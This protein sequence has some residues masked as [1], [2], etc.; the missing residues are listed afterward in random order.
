MIYQTVKSKYIYIYIYYVF[1]GLIIT[2][3]FS[4]MTCE[5]VRPCKLPTAIIPIALVRLLA[6]VR[7]KMLLQVRA[8]QIGLVAIGEIA[9]E[10][11]GPGSVTGVANTCGGIVQQA[12][13]IKMTH[14]GI[15]LTTS[16]TQYVGNGLRTH[17]EVVWRAACEPLIPEVGFGLEHFKIANID[18]LSFWSGC[19]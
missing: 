9:L 10:I 17:A 15:Q 18:R 12:D 3:M 2:C 14:A 16:G 19:F 8:L 11:S 4:V 1:P 5:L 7:T 6:G 13:R